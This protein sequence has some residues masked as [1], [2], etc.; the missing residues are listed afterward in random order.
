MTTV[1]LTFAPL[2]LTVSTLPC[3][4]VEA[5]GCEPLPQALS[6]AA[7][8]G[9]IDVCHWLRNERGCAWGW[10]VAA[11]ASRNGHVHVLQVR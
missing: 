10:E 9:H 8:A 2:S 7:G 3:T 5:A 11:E 6:A 4:A 1:V